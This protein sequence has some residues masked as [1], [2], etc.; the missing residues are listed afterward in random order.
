VGG[1]FIW[2]L[3]MDDFRGS[4]GTGKYPLL[5]A[6][7]DTLAVQSPRPRSSSAAY[8]D[9]FEDFSSEVHGGSGGRDRDRAGSTIY[10]PSRRYH[11]GLQSYSDIGDY[12]ER[13]ESSRQHV[14]SGLWCYISTLFNSIQYFYIH[15]ARQ[16]IG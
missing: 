8:F 4:C 11:D 1:A 10:R 6:I 2:S 14:Q 5:S 16:P 13:Q 9:D 3:E 7:A 15:R 12:N